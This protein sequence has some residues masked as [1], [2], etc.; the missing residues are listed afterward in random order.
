MDESSLN[1]RIDEMEKRILF[2]ELEVRKLSKQFRELSHAMRAF[3]CEEK[4]QE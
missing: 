1:R 3:A 4:E 2:L